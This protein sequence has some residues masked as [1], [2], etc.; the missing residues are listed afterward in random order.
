M[1]I[2][3]AFYSAC[4]NSNLSASVF[5]DFAKAFDMVNHDL[6]LSKLKFY[7]ISSD[8]LNLLTSYLKGRTQ[9]VVIKTDKS[10]TL[11]VTQGIPQGS[12]LGPLLFSIFINDL[13]LHISSSSCELFADDTTL[14]STDN[15]VRALTDNLNESLCQLKLWCEDNKMVVNPTKSESM[16]VCTWQKRQRLPT[17][18]LDLFYNGQ[19]IP[20]VTSHRHLGVILDQ[21]LQWAD[22][23]DMIVKKVSTKVYQLNCIKHFLDESTRKM[24]YHAYIQ[25]HFD[26]CSS[27][28]GH[29][30]PT[31]LRRL[32]SIQR[33]SL[34]AIHGRSV[35]D[36][37]QLYKLLNI[38]PVDKHIFLKDC[39]LMHS[40]FENK[41]PSHISNLFQPQRSS[42][43]ND[44]RLIVP[45]PKMDIYKMSFSYSGASSWNKLS[46]SL[47]TTIYLPAFKSNLVNTLFKSC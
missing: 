8:T 13:P 22:H 32:S 42:Y 6:L 46:P 31:H 24:F 4:N 7:G 20:Q 39:I 18:T 38:L 25:P 5:V 43:F 3:E 47:R 28:W 30:V 44:P 29:C 1:K 9:T 34:R 14:F 19:A 37:S 17:S 21:N 27:V 36:T 26:Y 15:N 45:L 23:V 40:T 41:V 33:R 2:T 12:T 10:N 16:L 11:P 35:E